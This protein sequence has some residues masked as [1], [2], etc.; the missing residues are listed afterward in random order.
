MLIAQVLPKHP[1]VSFWPDQ[2]AAHQKH[3]S[4]VIDVVYRHCGQKEC[5]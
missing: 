5:R 4:D 3:V 2:P 1:A